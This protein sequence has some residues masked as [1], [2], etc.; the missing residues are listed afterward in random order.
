M[1][2]N[3]EN[4]V[5]NMLR[6]KLGNLIF[7]VIGKKSVVSRAPDYSLITWSKA[8][9]ASRK[10]FRLASEWAHGILA[11]PA[12]ADYYRKI[13]AKGQVP[14]NRAIS[15]FMKRL[16]VKTID[17]TSYQGN[18]GDEIRLILHDP[19]LVT[20]ITIAIFDARGNLVEDAIADRIGETFQYG[21]RSAIAN[22]SYRTGTMVVRVANEVAVLPDTFDLGSDKRILRAG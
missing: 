5:T 6:G 19:Y 13:A 12:G 2:R 8:Q 20:R 7:R 17:L 11:D 3:R 10:R 18:P 15:D 9:K 14:Y 21:F 1:A 16:R 22:P 4:I